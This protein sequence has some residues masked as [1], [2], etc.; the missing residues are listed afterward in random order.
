[1]VTRRK[2][3]DLST[4]AARVE[5]AK[6]DGDPGGFIS[7]GLVTSDF[8]IVLAGCLE[9]DPELPEF[10]C[11]RIAL[12]VAHNPALPRPITAEV[13]LRLCSKHE[14]EYLSKP[15]QSFRL[16]TEISLW[17]T[18]DVPTTRIGATTLTFKPKQSKG[19]TERA[20]LFQVSQAT[21]GF[22]LPKH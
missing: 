12:K 15:K 2:D 9:F 21:V 1:M 13:L 8:A 10:E 20:K 16:L 4:L 14:R 17:S 11:K 7:G 6:A 19:F 3:N 18:V 22:E 5:Q